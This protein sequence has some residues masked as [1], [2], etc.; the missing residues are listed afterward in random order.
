LPVTRETFAISRLRA[1][2]APAFRIDH[3][4]ALGAVRIV[5]PVDGDVVIYGNGW[6]PLTG[7]GD[8]DVLRP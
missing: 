2:S 5:P 1:T 6:I 3:R 8:D 4:R 7:R